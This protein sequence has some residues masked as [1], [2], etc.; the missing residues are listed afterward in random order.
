MNDRANDPIYKT[1][2]WKKM[3]DDKNCRYL[4]MPSHDRYYGHMI[5]DFERGAAISYLVDAEDAFYI[6]NLLEANKN[7]EV[8]SPPK[9]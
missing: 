8:Q 2:E 9:V 6:S 1:E 4:A 3:V 7:A 5:W